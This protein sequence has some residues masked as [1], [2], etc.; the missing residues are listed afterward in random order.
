MPAEKDMARTDVPIAAR[1]LRS[2]IAGVCLLALD[3][4]GTRVGQLHIYVRISGQWFANSGLNKAAELFEYLNE[5]CNQ[6][7]CG[8]QEAL[9][10]T[11]KRD[12]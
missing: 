1:I 3:S 5:S 8:L 12:A 6:L 2:I 11:V 10:S 9:T 7:N 4:L